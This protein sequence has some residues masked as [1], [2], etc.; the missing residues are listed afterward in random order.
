MNIFPSWIFP[1]YEC[2]TLSRDSMITIRTFF[3]F[4]QCQS[5][6][7][8][9]AHISILKYVLWSSHNSFMLLS[10]NSDFVLPRCNIWYFRNKRLSIDPED[11]TDRRGPNTVVV[12]APLKYIGYL[13]PGDDINPSKLLP[14][15]SSGRKD[16]GRWRSAWRPSVQILERYI[17]PMPL[18]IFNM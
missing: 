13:Y 4:A 7:P 18:E 15:L 10:N 2:L 1:V 3:F 9:K 16:R 8:R 5:V 6:Y 17:T 12:D 11:E 14:L